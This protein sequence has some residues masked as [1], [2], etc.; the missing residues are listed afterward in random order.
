MHGGR[1]DSK[2]DSSAAADM[3]R[4]A[5][6]KASRARTELNGAKASEAVQ[7][8]KRDVICVTCSPFHSK[9]CSGAAALFCNGLSSS[10]DLVKIAPPN[11]G[12]Q[13]R[14]P[15]LGRQGCSLGAER[16]ARRV[17]GSDNL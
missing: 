6:V 7:K 17:H 15:A 16:R 4:T 13:T 11:N 3:D 1:R 14:E 2:L 12:R 9:K 10:N 5:R 8:R